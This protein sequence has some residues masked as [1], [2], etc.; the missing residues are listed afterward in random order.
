VGP[1]PFYLLAMSLLYNA[2]LI[3][4][5]WVAPDRIGPSIARCVA[6]IGFASGTGYA[7]WRLEW[8]DVWRHGMPGVRYLMFYIPYL[9]GAAA[10][11]WG[12]GGV[13]ARPGR[14]RTAVT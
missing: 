13:V 3:V 2:P 11:G 7:L 4:I 10:I 14:R 1:L 8:F 12:I 9:G 6:A 5:L